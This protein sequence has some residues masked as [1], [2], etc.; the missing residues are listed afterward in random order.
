MQI[1]P[2]E[3]TPI[4]R[5]PGTPYSIEL[6]DTLEAREVSVL[7][8]RALIALITPIHQ[9]QLYRIDYRERFHFE[10]QGHSARSHEM[11]ATSY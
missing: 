6:M 8:L 9:I 5:I 4:L 7:L 2:N 1:D 11:G 10:V 3:E